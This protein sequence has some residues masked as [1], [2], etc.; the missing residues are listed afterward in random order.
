MSLP[1]NRPPS[2]ADLRRARASLAPLSAAVAAAKR[3]A[4]PGATA[5]AWMSDLH[6][7]A[8]R[9]YPGLRPVPFDVYGHHVDCSANFQIALAELAA[10]R[11]AADLLILGGDLADSGCGG[12]APADEFAELQRLLDAHLPPGLPTLPLL[13]NHDHADKPMS[14]R[15]G[16]LLRGLKRDGWVDPVEDHDFYHAS[17]RH[18]WRFIALD[19]RQ[20]HNL[21][22]R[23][24][25]W[26]E[27]QL[28]SD[29]KTPTIIAVHRPFVSVGNWVDDH[30]LRDFAALALINQAPCVRLVLSGHTHKS[31]L[32]QYRRRLHAA[33]PAVAY[34]IGEACGW[35]CIV[36]GRRGVEAVFVKELRYRTFDHVTATHAL[37]PGGHRRLAPALFEDSA[38]CNPCFLPRELDPRR[39]S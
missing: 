15:L 18:G 31:A 26:L 29:P 27:A 14:K 3:R 8:R 21:S 7:H 33:F 34:G 25:A 12:E 17:V 13:G 38:L 24:R 5:V 39:R 20:D 19:S 30:R 23:Q 35:G 11:P 22:N 9:D 16:R 6:L 28:A 4:G 37:R 2:A 36:L 1:H 32:W 10:L